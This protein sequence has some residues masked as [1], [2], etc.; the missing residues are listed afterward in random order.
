MSALHSGRG[1]RAKSGK[2]IHFPLAHRRD[3]ISKITAR[4]AAAPMRHAEKQLR[5]ALQ[6]QVDG[7]HRKGVPDSVVETQVRALESEIRAE[8]WRLVLVPS[9]PTGAA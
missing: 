1:G 2:I 9:Q 3:L 4:M 8:L 6:R 7:L 5:M